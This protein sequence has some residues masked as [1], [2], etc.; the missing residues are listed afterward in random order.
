MQVDWISAVIAAQPGVS[1]GYQTGV[2]LTLD[3]DGQVTK[4]RPAPVD[5]CDETEPSHSKRYRVVCTGPGSLYTSGNPV[6]L[7][8]GHNLFG[9]CDALELF[10]EA[11][12]WIRQTAGLFP[13]PATWDSCKMQGPRYTRLDLTRSYRFASEGECKAWIRQVAAVARSRHGAAKL[14]G[15]ST[16]MWGEGSRRWSFKVYAKQQEL[17]D[18]VKRAKRALWMRDD[19]FDWAAGV[20]RFE[21][22][23]RT[24]ELQEMP[25]KVSRLHGPGAR[26]AAREIWQEYFDRIVF[27]ENASMATP[28]LIE[29]TLPSHLAVKLAAWRG[30][31]DLRKMLSKTTFYRVRQEILQV[32]G[33]DIASPPPAPESVERLAGARLD[34]AGWDP[35]PIAAHCVDQHRG[36]AKEYG[37]F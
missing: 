10:F 36:L 12:V 33:V 4:E 1:L 13:G 27:N 29:A 30:G 24:P 17:L 15:T 37:L 9:S 23:L 18:L 19:L 11:G 34:A 22:T 25:E 14:Y 26:D 32:A 5:L 35:E 8:Q 21:L 2:H 31:A 20:A 3:R 16:A 6:K 28:S 7:L